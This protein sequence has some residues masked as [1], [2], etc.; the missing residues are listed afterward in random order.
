M[1]KKYSLFFVLLLILITTCFISAESL[2]IDSAADLY[3]R[4][5]V[6]NTGDSIKI[7]IEEETTISYKSDSKALKSYNLN[8]T[9]GE[10]SGLFSFVPQGN[11]EENTSS[12]DKDD[13]IIINSIQGR[14]TQVD[15]NYLTIS[16]TKTYTINNK[17]SKVVIGGVVNIKDVYMNT[18]RSSNIMDQTLSITTLLDNDNTII[19]SED[20][21]TVI[22]NPDA[23]SDFQEETQLSEEKKKELLLQYFNKLINVIF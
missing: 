3:S 22:T 9:G 19:T 11:V 20:L 5:V 6:Y 12:Q 23:T 1:Q 21:A 18:V 13:F 10:L 16:G 8:I 7:L 17:T 14:I 15:N 4:K 2:W